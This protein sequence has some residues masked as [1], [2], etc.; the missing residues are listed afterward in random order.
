MDTSMKWNN[1]KVNKCPQC[2]Q[3][4][5]KFATYTPTMIECKCGFKI[6][7]SRVKEIVEKMLNKDLEVDY[8]QGYDYVG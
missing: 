8:T 5:A 4:W 3:E 7:Q 2:N 6:R 1:L